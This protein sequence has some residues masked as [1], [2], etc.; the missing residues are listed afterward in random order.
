MFTGAKASAK[1]FCV[2]GAPAVKRKNGVPSAPPWQAAPSWLVGLAVQVDEIGA[3]CG[4]ASARAERAMPEG[5]S[6]RKIGA[7]AP[8]SKWPTKV[9]RLPPTCSCQ[10]MYGTLPEKAI[11]GRD[12]SLLVFEIG[13]PPLKSSKWSP[14]TSRDTKIACRP[15]PMSSSHTTHGTVG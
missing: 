4:F 1:S 15:P 9:R 7:A 14:P 6:N 3:R 8:P 11:S 5:V 12:E 13:R 2:P 10:E